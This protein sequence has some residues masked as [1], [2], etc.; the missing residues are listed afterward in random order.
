MVNVVVT[1]PTIVDIADVAA[2]EF[3][4]VV[5]VIIALDWQILVALESVGCL[6]VS[7]QVVG[8]KKQVTS[9]KVDVDL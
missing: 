7:V 6:L 5:V 4:V 1:E 8:P 2:V 3:I 9:K